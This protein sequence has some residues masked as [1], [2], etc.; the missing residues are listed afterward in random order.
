MSVNSHLCINVKIRLTNTSPRPTDHIVQLFVSDHYASITP[1]VKRLRASRRIHLAASESQQLS[2]ELGR[3][4]L[5]F[6]GIN[7]QS[8]VEAGTF[9]VMIGALSAD[10]E[11]E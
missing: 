5:E 9:T 3:E 4:S 7:C 6:I 8:V 10:F 11:I 1:P 2:F